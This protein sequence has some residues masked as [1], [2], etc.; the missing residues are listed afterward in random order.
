MIVYQNDNVK[1]TYD[2]FKERL[3]QTWS[4]FAS[5][6]SFRKG[7]DETV[8]FTKSN[9]VKTILSDALKQ[10]VVKPEDAT[11]AA[12]VMPKLIAN[13]MKSMAFVVPE[14]VFTKLSLQRFSKS[15][16]EANTKYFS[17]KP[18]AEGWLNQQ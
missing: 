4:G 6:D 18:E 7:I 1:I 3:T 15:S 8:K 14:S 5:S 12:S 13:G 9:P 17:N 11:Y 10:D 16:Q 2:Q